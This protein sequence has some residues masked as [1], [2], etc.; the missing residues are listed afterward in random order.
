ML[1]KSRAR[2]WIQATSKGKYYMWWCRIRYLKSY[3]RIRL[4][5]STLL[6]IQTMLPYKHTFAPPNYCR[7]IQLYKRFFSGYDRLSCLLLIQP[8]RCS[9]S[10]LCSSTVQ[11]GLVRLNWRLLC[12]IMSTANCQTTRCFTLSA[13]ISRPSKAKKSTLPMRLCPTHFGVALRLTS[14]LSSLEV[15]RVV[16]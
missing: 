6:L 13:P 9:R 2:C 16:C 12:S 14:K 7:M 11:V 15:P 4:V 1:S 10:R 8:G 3:T 5:H